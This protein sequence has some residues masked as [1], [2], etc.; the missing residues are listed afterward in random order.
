MSSATLLAVFAPFLTPISQ[1]AQALHRIFPFAR[2]LFEDKVANFWCA[3]NVVVKLR[4]L[5][6]VP[7]LARL[8]LVTTSFAL[9]PSVAAMIWVSWRA[10]CDHGARS[11]VVPPPTLSM[12]PYTLFISS[13][14]FFLFSFQVHEKSILLPLLPATLLMAA[15][16]PGLPGG[17]WE[18]GVLL[19]N[20]GVFRCAGLLLSLHSAD[21]DVA[22]SM[23]PLLKRDGLGTAYVSLTLLW[24]HFI[25]NDPFALP[26]GFIKYLSLVRIRSSC[27]HLRMCMLTIAQTTYTLIGVLHLL[28]SIASPP[29][30][31]PDLFVVLNL[32]LCA[33]VFGL[34][35][36]W[37]MK[38]Q[39]E[40]SWA[41]IGL[42]HTPVS[43]PF[44]AP[45]SNS[46]APSRVASP[47]P[48][49]RAMSPAVTAVPSRQLAS[50][51][52]HGELTDEDGRRSASIRK[53]HASGERAMAGLFD[54]VDPS[55]VR[56]RSRAR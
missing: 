38:R 28:D 30:H 47:M 14:A 31:L 46:R 55:R 11:V 27:C 4:E 53:R 17:D 32:T 39:V 12:L 9:L 52:Q 5:A 1:L 19:N 15:S 3:L 26:S 42:S 49:Q 7:I 35:F 37:G 20:V 21:V 36:L 41:L 25:G 8:A 50:S 51:Y 56:P 33:S 10:G 6:S 40:E 16:E 34:S 45:A 23:W 54:G 48:S 18:W 43:Q 24:N 13:M 29:A 2:G 44:S 22:H